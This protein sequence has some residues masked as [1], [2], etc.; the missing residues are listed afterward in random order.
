[1]ATL[2]ALVVLGS[3]SKL[4]NL[5]VENQ[6]TVTLYV[7]VMHSPFDNI[8]DAQFQGRFSEAVS[9][10]RVATLDVDVF[11]DAGYLWVKP[12]G[13][14]WG[15]ELPF[16]IDADRGEPSRIVIEGETCDQ[17]LTSIEPSPAPS[18]SPTP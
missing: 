16:L 9:K 17:F 18:T 10:G 4:V 3:C 11:Y 1:V 2:A 7:Q 8:D 15:F 14:K 12:E 13:G 6:C 5:E